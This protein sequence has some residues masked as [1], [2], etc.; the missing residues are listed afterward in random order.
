M[1]VPGGHENKGPVLIYE[2]L[3]TAFLLVAINQSASFGS[4]QPFAV[5]LTIFCNICIFGA[6]SGGHFN[7]A[8]TIAVFVKEAKAKNIVFCILIFL[9]EFVG[10][11]FGVLFV[12]ISQEH[13]SDRKTISPG[14]ALLCPGIKS[15]ENELVNTLCNADGVYW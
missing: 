4:F 12:L 3:G 6:V 15:A 11:I 13:D 7:P 10:A 8:V 14:I 9:A 1:E 5:G 2:M